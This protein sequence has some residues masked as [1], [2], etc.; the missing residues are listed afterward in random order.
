[1]ETINPKPVFTSA[2]EKLIAVF[3]AGSIRP[4]PED[5]NLLHYSYGYVHKVLSTLVREGVLTY[6]Q[7]QPRKMRLTTKGLEH[8]RAEMPMASEYSMA[9]SDQNHPGTSDAH[10]LL[11]QR[12]GD[13][14]AFMLRSCVETGAQRELLSET[15]L[16]SDQKLGLQNPLYLSTKEIKLI[17]NAIAQ[18]EN[19]EA[20]VGR[21]QISRASGV[22]FSKGSCGPVYGLIGE[23]YMRMHLSAEISME[24]RTRAVY[25]NIIGPIRPDAEMQHIILYDR[26]E[27]MLSGLETYRLPSQN[28]TRRYARA[29][30]RNAAA[31]MVDVNAWRKKTTIFRAITDYP[32]WKME[33]RILPRHEHGCVCLWMLTRYTIEEI[34]KAVAA[35]FG[36]MEMHGMC[37]Y[38]DGKAVSQFLDCNIVRLE[39]LRKKLKDADEEDPIPLLCWEY[40][41]DFVS[42]FLGEGPYEIWPVRGDEEANYLYYGE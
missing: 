13:I 3:M 12:E 1:M 20:K 8:L 6:T 14:Q 41:A 5:F 37:L 21:E 9:T 17:N 18:K 31:N 39:S 28:R 42:C 2:L 26:D 38:L 10:K 22:I 15:L 32:V 7:D 27:D 11:M 23:E 24:G 33:F 16:A 29:P 36:D 19:R 35:I 4:L 34:F 30:Q 25:R 40:Q